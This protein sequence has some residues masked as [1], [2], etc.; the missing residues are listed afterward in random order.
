METCSPGHEEH[1]MVEW[2]PSSSVAMSWMPFK[3]PS[4]QAKDAKSPAESTAIGRE[5]TTFPSSQH[6]GSAPS[7]AFP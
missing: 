3:T 7:A 2:A 4:D 5:A 1:V 6:A